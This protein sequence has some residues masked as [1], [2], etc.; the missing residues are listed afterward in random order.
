MKRV[1]LHSAFWLVYLLQDTVLEIVWVGPA[2]KNIPE[3]V[4]FGMAFKAAIAAWI[5]KLIFT[6]FILYVA[7]P[8]IVK[9][10]RKLFWIAICLIKQLDIFKILLWIHFFSV[11]GCN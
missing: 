10:T 2:L 7:I 4:Q 1:L 9:G 5:P 8:E 3:N 11:E 6:Y